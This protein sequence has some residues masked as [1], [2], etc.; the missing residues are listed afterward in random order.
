MNDTHAHLD[1]LENLEEIIKR[2]KGMQ[3]ITNSVNIKSCQKNL[4]IKDKFPKNVKLAVGLYPEEDISNNKLEELK[5][6]IKK[7]KS[8]ISAMGEIGMDFKHEKPSKEIQEFIFKA[9]LDLAKELKIPSIIHTRKAEKEVL[10]ILE[11]YKNQIIILHC[12]SGNFKLVKR[13]IDLGFYFSIPT[14]IVRSEHFQR[15]VV[16]VPR[17]RLLTETD[18]PLQS[19]FKDKPNEPAFIKESIK[20]ISEIWNLPTTKTEKIIENNFYKIFTTD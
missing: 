14:S 13:A 15:L 3:I 7:N 2:A 10:D 4:E 16:E 8:K 11:N 5:I 6:F 17:E 19:P 12:F 18:A 1:L 9:Q 20:K